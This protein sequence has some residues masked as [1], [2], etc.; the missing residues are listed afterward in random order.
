MHMK[1]RPTILLRHE[2]AERELRADPAR[3]DRAIAKLACCDHKTVASMRV[4]LVAGGAIPAVDAKARRSRR[5]ASSAEIRPLSQPSNSPVPSAVAPAD[6]PTPTPKAPFAEHM[7]FS[8]LVILAGDRDDWPAGNGAFGK[9]LLEALR[10]GVVTT[11]DD[12][13]W[14]QF[15][16]DDGKLVARRQ[17]E[18]PDGLRVERESFARWL[19]A[20]GT[21]RERFSAAGRWAGVTA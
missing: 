10:G 20:N 11:P 6:T 2:L 4:L 18:R 17:R 1:D 5:P 12:L 3:S 13:N 16:G 14:I 21:G 7:F 9:R 19:R 15:F 8:R